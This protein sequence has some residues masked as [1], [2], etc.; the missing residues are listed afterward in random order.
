MKGRAPSGTLLS[1]F[2]VKESYE[3]R[4]R[5]KCRLHWRCNEEILASEIDFQILE[6]LFRKFI[7]Q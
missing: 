1:L 3:R 5:S 2:R 6:A 7:Q 4:G